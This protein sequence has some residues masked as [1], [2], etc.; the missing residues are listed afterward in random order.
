VK[1]NP[2]QSCKRIKELK[3]ISP[4]GK[5]DIN[6]DGSGDIKVYCD[7]KTDGGGWTLVWVSNGNYPWAS[8]L[9]T[10]TWK[11]PK[12]HKPGYEYSIDASDI[13]FSEVAMWMDGDTTRYFGFEVPD[14]FINS[15]AFEATA[16]SPQTC[17]EHSSYYTYDGGINK[18]WQQY[19]TFGES[20]ISN[21]RFAEWGIDLA[22][23]SDCD[24][25]WN[26]LALYRN[27]TSHSVAAW[28]ASGVTLWGWSKTASTQRTPTVSSIAQ[29]DFPE[30]WIDRN[31]WVMVR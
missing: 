14:T 27:S 11:V 31:V 25:S 9:D 19:Y 6:P 1:I 23:I 28:N 13:F 24:S 29:S 4:S 7:M 17:I 20:L 18:Y 5:H 30:K 15:R 10:E 3:W 21:R 12:N 26:T 2:K 22:T 8:F 16:W